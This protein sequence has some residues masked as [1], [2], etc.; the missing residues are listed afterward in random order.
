VTIS[1]LVLEKMFLSGKALWAKPV[2]FAPR[3]PRCDFP[4]GFLVV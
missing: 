1:P 3:H 2:S 4:L